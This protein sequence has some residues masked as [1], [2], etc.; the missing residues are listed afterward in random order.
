MSYTP[1]RRT[2]QGRLRPWLQ[3]LTTLLVFA[4]GPAFAQTPVVVTGHD[5][6]VIGED[7]TA[8]FSGGPGN[9]KDWVGIYPLDVAPGSV[10]Y[11]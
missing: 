3:C 10:G 2:V 7:I 4:A 9:P 1:N 6:Y 11:K 8:E 5:A